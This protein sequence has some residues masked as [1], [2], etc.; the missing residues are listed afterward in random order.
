MS[1]S[2][3]GCDFVTSLLTGKRQREVGLVVPAEYSFVADDENC[4]EI[5]EKEPVKRKEL[6]PT[7]A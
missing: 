7:V 5:L 2:P 6:F 1:S 3:L 4:A